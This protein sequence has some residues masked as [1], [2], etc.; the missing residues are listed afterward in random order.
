MAKADARLAFKA[1]QKRMA[2]DKLLEALLWAKYCVYENPRDYH[3]ASKLRD[4][5]DACGG[6]AVADLRYI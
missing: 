4:G 3:M 1:G 5:G 2:A 6:S